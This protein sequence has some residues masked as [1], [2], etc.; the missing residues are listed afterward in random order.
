L[1]QDPALFA[2]AFHFS[3]GFD[4]HLSSVQGS[5]FKVQRQMRFHFRRRISL[6]CLDEAVVDEF[7]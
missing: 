7:S 2:P 5:R 6:L 1:I 3:F 4:A